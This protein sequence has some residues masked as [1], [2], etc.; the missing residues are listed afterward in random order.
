[1]LEKHLRYIEVL[2]MQWTLLHLA[3]QL[4]QRWLPSLRQQSDGAVDEVFA[5]ARKLGGVSRDFRNLGELRKHLLERIVETGSSLAEGLTAQPVRGVRFGLRKRRADDMLFIARTLDRCVG[6]R[7]GELTVNP[8]AQRA[9]WAAIS[10]TRDSSD[11]PRRGAELIRHTC[12]HV[13]NRLEDWLE[14]E[15]ESAERPFAATR[16]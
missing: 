7:S 9:L 12:S 4:D 3:V 6:M 1:M 11:P 14:E 10:S 15:R 16:A 13:L 2:H 8:D 5:I